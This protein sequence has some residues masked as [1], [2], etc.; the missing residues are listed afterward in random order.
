MDLDRLIFCYN[1]IKG[2]FDNKIE[3]LESVKLV[4]Q[5][6]EYWKPDKVKIILL[7]E[8]HVFTSDDDRNKKTIELVELPY[9]PTQYAKFVYCLSY[10]EKDLLVEKNNQGRDGT[11]GFWK[12]LYS[13]KNHINH[14]SDFRPILKKTPFD[15]RIMNKIRLLTE[16]K[17]K[18]IWL[19]D[20]SI[21]GLYKDGAKLS[22]MKE[23][24]K[25]SWDYYIRDQ[26]E[27]MH[28]EYIICIG[29]DVAKVVETDLK[30]IMGDNYC[31]IP[32]PNARLLSA[33]H[34]V[35]FQRY[36]EVCSKI[37]K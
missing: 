16:L 23:I 12:V 13:C 19:V 30:I 34:L 37:I 22:R 11:P 8:S 10:G 1:Q 15:K 17:A 18:G 7:A 27:E 2:I 25:L 31:I 20:S 26:I 9:Y 33:E 35:N 3:P 28:P 6:R 24:I 4:K 14:N 21:I 36:Y 5:Y 29:K 32:Q